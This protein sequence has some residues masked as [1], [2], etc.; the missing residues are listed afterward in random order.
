MPVTALV[1][2][3]HCLTRVLPM[4]ERRCPACGQNVDTN[5]PEPTREQVQKAALG[6]ATAQI[7]LGA[8][9]ADV[10]ANL[11]HGGVDAHAA[12]RAVANANQLKVAARLQA[13]KTNMFYGA[14]WCI[15]GF[16]VTAITYQA[17]AAGGGRYILAWGAIL[18]GGIQFFRGVIQLGGE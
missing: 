2:C 4:K 6:V 7:L 5:P 10:R 18:F 1:T 14:L 8:D 9:P 13:A 15:G 3:P 17:A 16:A 11:T 12:A